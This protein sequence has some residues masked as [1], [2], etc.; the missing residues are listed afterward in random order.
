[1]YDRLQRVAGIERKICGLQADQLEEIAGYVKDRLS[2]DERAGLSSG[3]E[4]HRGMVAEVAIARHVSVMTAQAHM[5]DAYLL[6]TQNPSTLAA[7]RRGR[8]GLPAARAIANETTL[9]DSTEQVL[10]ADRLIADEAVDVL[11]GKVRA[12]AE[13]RVAPSTPRQPADAG[14]ASRPIGTSASTT[15]AQG[16]PT[17]TPTSQ[18]SRVSRASSH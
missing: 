4:Q 10:A 17:S 5:A 6:T 9:L 7:L 2:Y 12:L 3:P 8:L 1:M 11:P 15:S 13:R 16:C 18:P 14:A